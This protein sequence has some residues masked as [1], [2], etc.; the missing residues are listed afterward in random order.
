MATTGEGFRWRSAR[1]NCKTIVKPGDAL[2][3]SDH[4]PKQ[5]KALFEVAK[6][7]G[8][9]GIVAKRRESCYEERRSREWLKIKIRHR[10]GVRGRRLSPNPKAAAPI[11]DPSC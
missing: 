8:L 5:G 6:S 2:R 11:L 3:F 4:Y 9:E 10:S 1:R 7:K